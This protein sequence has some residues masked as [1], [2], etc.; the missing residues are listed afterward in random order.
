M[1]GRALLT[2]PDELLLVRRRLPLRAEWLLDRLR[3]YAVTTIDP[4]EVL[5]TDL[6]YVLDRKMPRAEA[7]AHIEF[8]ADQDLL[9]TGDDAI[10]L[11]PFEYARPKEC[12]CG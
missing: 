10:T 11:W 4:G 2:D 9:I 3:L 1:R 7:L 5:V 6:E 8:L 12:R